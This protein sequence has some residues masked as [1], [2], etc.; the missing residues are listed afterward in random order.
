MNASELNK[1]EIKSFKTI[2]KSY[3]P[4]RNKAFEKKGQFGKNLL[5][6]KRAIKPI[7]E[8]TKA[9]LDL[10]DKINYDLSKYY[11]EFQHRNCG[12]EKKK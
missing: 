4:K 11:I 7:I 10:F 8:K 5:L 1:E 3:L 2:H 9:I 6:K 12:F